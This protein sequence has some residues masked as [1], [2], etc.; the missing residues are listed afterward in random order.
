MLTHVNE[1]DNTSRIQFKYLLTL[2]PYH[3]SVNSVD[4]RCITVDKSYVNMWYLVTAKNTVRSSILFYFVQ[5]EYQIKY[6]RLSS[7]MADSYSGETPGGRSNPRMSWEINFEVKAFHSSIA[8]VSFVQS[9]SNSA[10]A[11]QYGC[12]QV[13][14]VWLLEQMSRDL[15]QDIFR[16]WLLYKDP[17][18]LLADPTCIC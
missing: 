3:N 7:T 18:D 13:P 6:E 1:I 8:L 5:C 14:N 2:S 16:N 9:L 4:K 10:Q 11:Q 17:R 12:G 15:L